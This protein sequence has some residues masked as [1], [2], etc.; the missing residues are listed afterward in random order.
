MRSLATL[1][2]LIVVVGAGY[3]VYRTQVASSGMTEASP[4][5]QI[6]VTGIRSELLTIGQ[7]ERQYVIAHGAYGTLDQLRQEGAPMLGIDARGYAFSAEPDGSRSFKVTATPTDPNRTGWPT[8]TIDETMEIT[9][10]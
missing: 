7:T 1:V 3:F 6:D 9:K 5:A 10:R 4:Q 2:G 8:L